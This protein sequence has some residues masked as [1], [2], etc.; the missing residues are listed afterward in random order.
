MRSFDDGGTPC[1]LMTQRGGSWRTQHADKEPSIWRQCRSAKA[2][3]LG[4]GGRGGG[5]SIP[6]NRTC[7][8]S[9]QSGAKCMQW[10]AAGTHMVNTNAK[11]DSDD[12][13]VPVKAPLNVLGKMEAHAQPHVHNGGR[14][15]RPHKE[16][17]ACIQE[18]WRPQEWP[19]SR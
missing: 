2:A 19:H 14:F 10:C 15:A 8:T 1:M 18:G 17:Q 9:K 7:E 5:L 13:K 16:M 6:N 11:L 3:G 12:G 4:A